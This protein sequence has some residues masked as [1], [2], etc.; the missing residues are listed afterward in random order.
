M[1][2]TETATETTETTAPNYTGIANLK[3]LVLALDTDGANISI[4]D[5]GIADWFDN[6]VEALKTTTQRGLPASVRL[7]NVRTAINEFY[8]ANAF[9]LTEEK[10]NELNMLISK[11][12]RM[13][14]EI[15]A[16]TAAK[17]KSAN[18]GETAQE[19]E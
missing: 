10:E 19:P 14:N 5:D 2:K 7:E 8:T 13:E 9:P 12:K 16:E 3:Q 15:K 11:R 18:S 4:D 17:E 1:A 6:T